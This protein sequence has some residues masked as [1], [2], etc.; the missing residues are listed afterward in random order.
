MFRHDS[1]H[2]GRTN[3]TGP[4]SPQVK[5]VFQANDGIVSSPSIGH[6]GTIYVGSAG[7]YQA[8]G[9]SSLYAINPGDGSLK[10]R[11]KSD[12]SGYG[13]GFFSSPAIDD[14]G[15]IF[16]GSA[17]DFLY[18]IE[19]SVTY[20]KLAWRTKFGF[21]PVYSSP[22]LGSDGTVYVGG[23]DFTLDALNPEDGIHKWLFTSGWCIFSS[24]A[25]R[26]DGSI[27]VGSKDHNVYCLEDSVNYG[28]VAWQYSAGVFYDGHLFDSSP[29]IGDD[30]TVYIGT[31]QYGAWGQTP[32]PIDTAF[33]AINPDG[34]EK[35]KYA[36]GNGVESS[37]AIGHD[38][39][40]YVGALDS[41]LY[42]FEDAGTHANLKWKFVTGGAVDGSPTVDGSGIIYVGS[43][44]SNMYAINPDGTERWRFTTGDG[45]E[46]SPTIDDHGNL[47]FGSFDGSL[48][49]LGTGAPDVGVVSSDMP[50]SVQTGEIYFPVVTV[51][52][53]RS[54]VQQVGVVCKISADLV[55]VYDDTVI[56]SQVLSG[57]TAL[58]Q[59]SQWE[60]DSTAGVE[61]TIDAFTLLVEDDNPVN[62]SLML[63]IFSTEEV[64]FV[65]GDA[66]GS[67]AVD[68]D[69]I[70]HLINYIFGG[71]PPPASVEAGDADCSDSVDID[72]VVYLI[73]Y[74]FGG[75]M[76]PCSECS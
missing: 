58:A 40:I 8:V 43:R 2:T 29:A 5:W 47:L 74:I 50:Y 36:I 32:V 73:N 41:C 24:P 44:D 26:D 23:L 62:D 71:G 53:F 12:S 16:V 68:I 30:G 13:S 4:A 21:F 33:F 66:D 72:D 67:G 19:D 38:G 17:D 69:D 10:W 25:L 39:T 7:Y 27:V 54:Q 34:T 49:C 1:K 65:C 46:S 61:Y 59:F 57:S 75:G 42:A 11:L 35:W 70:V 37:P 9:D 6:D 3:F 52:N 14:D 63:T 45:I 15:T 76:P 51:R 64:S 48:Y 56:V 55:D 31:D 22:V 20:G 18:R 60:V 28:K